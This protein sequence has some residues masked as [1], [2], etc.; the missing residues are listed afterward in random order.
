MRLS[1]RKRCTKLEKLI[2]SKLFSEERIRPGKAERKEQD[3]IPKTVVVRN[4]FEADYDRIVGSSSVRRLQDKAQVFPLQK[5]DVVR[6]RLTHSLEVSALARSL[7]NAVGRQLEDKK[8]FEREDTEKLS[9]LLQTAGMIHDLGN[10]PF[11]HYGEQV[12]QNWVEERK[13]NLGFKDKQEE[14]DFLC[15]DGNVQNLRIVAKLQT[16]NDPYGANFTYATLATI[17][18][19]PYKSSERPCG[20]KK[21]GYFKSEE[22]LIKKIREATGLKEGIRHPATFLLEAADDIIYLCDDIEDGV[23]KGCIDWNT[24]YAKLCDKCIK[25]E[26]YKELFKKIEGNQPDVNMEEAEQV[27]ARARVF[28]NSVQTFLFKKAVEA[29]LNH[30]DSIMLGT[31]K[32]DLLKDEEKFIDELKG[33]TAEFCFSCK[34]VLALEV[35]GHRVLTELLNILYDALKNAKKEDIEATKTYAGK[36]YHII[37]ANY[38]YIALYDYETGKRRSF[39]ELGVYD[40]LHLIVDFVSGMTDSYAVSLYKELTGISLPE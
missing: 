27:L 4:A 14:E 38:K 20:K 16:M 40:K 11:G 24:E 34:E 9:A 37:S 29:F 12:I 35:A 32:D 13:K 26:K 39:E 31:H 33:I 1:I 3:V 23:K 8:I 28:R 10:P 22:S 18:K 25:D 19:Y 6:T 36:I 30:Y 15:F 17:M 5:N 21:F 2:W 7:G